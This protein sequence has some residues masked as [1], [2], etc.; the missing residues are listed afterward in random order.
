MRNVVGLTLRQ[1]VYQNRAFWRNPPAAFF[2]FAFPLIFLVIFTTIFGREAARFFTGGILT[3]SI[4]SATF[5]NLAMSVTFAREEGILKRIR[6]TPLPP[7]A[8][9]AGRML[10]AVAIA[11]LLTVIVIGYG[12]LAADVEV[13][14]A[15][16]PV[17]L[18][19]LVVGSA[20]L[21]A[22][23]LAV[24]TVIPNADAAPAV[25][26]AAVLPLYFISNVFTSAE[27]L[28]DWLDAISKVFP[29]RHL[30]DAV[31]SV[32]SAAP[33]APPF[34]AGELA[35]VAAWGVGAALFALRFFRWEP[36]R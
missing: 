9:L 30:A 24:S 18:V 8:Y 4:V 10:H 5:T 31:A 7:L 13:P 20:A 27:N 11:L 33:A 28:P 19:A 32:Y 22:L 3:L 23:G 35:I 17:L 14:W 21:C 34:P 26:N 36:R 16:L 2:T 15:G 1:V 29:I 25:V 6:G 12:A